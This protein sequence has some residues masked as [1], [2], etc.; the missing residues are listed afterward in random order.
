MTKTTSKF[1]ACAAL[2]SLLFVT[3]C[4]ELPGSREQQGAAIGGLS[5]AAVGAAV[6]GS[7]H[8]LLGALLG[9]ALG[10]G[11]G[12]LIGANTDKISGRDSTSARAASQKAQRE[13]VTVA[14]A[15]NATSAD[16]NNDGFVTMDEVVALHQAGLG[17]QEL[18]E[19][20]RASGQVF[21]L[22]A[23]QREHLRSQG[24]SQRVLDEL[25]NINSEARERLMT[26]GSVLGRP[27]TD[28]TV[29]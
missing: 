8:R 18:L 1:A 4:S 26:T 2:G 5:G 13:P 10:A 9:G 29:R 16:V 12:Y 23:Q 25:P 28:S 21:E 7:E 19:R 3:G 15:R 20:L 27:P 14:Q 24:I 17:D 22:T 11:G 6:G